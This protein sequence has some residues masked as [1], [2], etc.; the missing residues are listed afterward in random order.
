MKKILFI[1]S[2]ERLRLKREFRQLSISNEETGS[3]FRFP[4][5]SI[6]AVVIDNPAVSITPHILSLFAKHRITLL[7]VDPQTRY[8]SLAFS[9]F[10]SSHHARGRITKKQFETLLLDKRASLEIAKPLIYAKHINRGQKE[11]FDDIAKIPTMEALLSYEAKRSKEYWRALGIKRQKRQTDFSGYNTIN[12][13]LN[14]GYA[15]V[16]AKTAVLLA[17]YGLIP[18]LGVFHSDLANPFALADDLMEVF[19]F[20]VE[21]KAICHIEKIRS[22]DSLS[23]GL[24]KEAIAALQLDIFFREKR[25]DMSFFMEQAVISFQKLVLG[26]INL[27]DFAERI[28]VDKP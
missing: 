7:V 5:D 10:F 13:F 28:T 22:S 6:E 1:S 26:E 20:A 21:K 12:A 9:E 24:K 8:P 17:G 23:S 16:R 11:D 2:R 14:Y 15:V 18:S 4:L 27:S 25:V 3:V 19:R